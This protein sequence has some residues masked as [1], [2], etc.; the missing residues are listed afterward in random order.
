[1]DTEHRAQEEIELDIEIE[2]DE[3]YVELDAQ[4]LEDGDVLVKLERTIG[5]ET[6]MIYARIHPKTAMAFAERLKLAALQG[7]SIKHFQDDLEA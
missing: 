5:Q 1:M 3:D 4:I 6:A 2:E 7:F